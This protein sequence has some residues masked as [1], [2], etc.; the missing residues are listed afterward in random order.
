MSRRMLARTAW[1]FVASLLLTSPLAQGEAAEPAELFVVGTVYSRHQS[2]PGYDLPALRR[3][4]LAI[5]PDVIVTDCTPTEIRE[6]KVHASKV[7]YPQVVFPLID[8]HG[9]RVYAGEPDEPLFTQIVQPLAQALSKYAE[10][11]PTRVEA[12]KE[13]E[14]AMYEVLK[15][16]WRSPAQAQDETTA[17]LLKA[18]EAAHTAFYGDILARGNKAWVEHWV[19]VVRRAVA[20][21]PGKRVL[22]LPGLHNRHGILEEL[23]RDTN[24]KL[25]DVKSWL[26]EQKSRETGAAL[27]SSG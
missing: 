7:E 24:V 6:R 15:L 25:V 2:M 23:R 14:R 9:Y 26:T 11:N 19:A 8:E 5:D 20:E 21:N 12:L 27:G 4:V 17:M 16:H 3:L 10:T 13:Y 22:A 1:S 18:N